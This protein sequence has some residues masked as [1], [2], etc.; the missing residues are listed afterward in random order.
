MTQFRAVR[1]SWRSILLAMAT[2]LV[3]TIPVGAQTKPPNSNPKLVISPPGDGLRELFEHPDDWRQARALT[4]SLLYPDHHL[5]HFTDAE[6]Q[7]W[8]GMMRGWGISLELEVG[9]IKPWGHTAEDTFRAEQPMWDRALRLGADIGA[10]A[11]DEPLVASRNALHQTDAYA[12]DQ[13]ARFIGLVRQHYPAIR[14]G[15]IEPY[16]AIP[17]EDHIVWLRQLSH[18]LREQNVRPLD[19]YRADI[20]WVAFTKARRGSWREVAS[21]AA[22]TRG[23][24]VPFSLIYWA[25]PYPSE[26]AAGLARED[27]WYVEV[28]GQGNA[29]AEAGVHPDQF[30]LESWLPTPSRIVPETTEFTFTRSVLDFG[31]KFVNGAGQGRRDSK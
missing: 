29:A 5:V 16:P 8:F 18:R 15:D 22:G 21:L 17:L 14:I 20:D 23:L 25:S 2:L 3:S 11:M 24:G 10:I 7:K 6:L 9:A 4:G 27:T 19:F 28:L 12:V 1:S 31:Q 26:K 30:V 13:T